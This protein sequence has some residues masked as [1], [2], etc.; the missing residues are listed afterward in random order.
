MRDE[1][2]RGRTDV[3]IVIPA[4]FGDAAGRSLFTGRDKP[5]LGLLYDPSKGAQ[6][7][8]VRGILTQ[9]VMQ[10][11]SKEMFNGQSGRRMLDESLQRLDRDSSMAPADRSALRDMLESVQRWYNRPQSGSTSTNAPTSGGLSVP[12]TVNE[13]PITARQDVAYNGYAHSF[14]GMG[15]Q[16]VLFISIEIGVGILLERQRGLWKRL[17]S[18]P[19]SKTMLLGAKALS[20]TILAL[21]IFAV[22]FA[23]GM[24]VLGVRIE[25]SLAGFIAVLV[26]CSLMA[27][28]FGLL[29]A[30]LGRTPQ[31]AR[32]VSVF[33][34]LI[35]VMV[36]G[37]WVPSFLFP[38]WLQK[39]ALIVPAR[40]AVDGLDAMTWRGLGFATALPAVLVLLAF[41]LVFGALAVARFRWQEE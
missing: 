41:A 21:A 38:A 2:K 25:G 12:Y 11:V 37:A 33:A 4:G 1:V 31:A 18:A 30:A 7:G 15:V 3:G 26:A 23:F 24:I 40:W 39:A 22:M 13:Q 35:M 5:V 8:M 32:G 19:L 16:F 20:G 9:Y 17:R 36:G 27:A 29:I 14:S 6:L 10:S 28:T 34:V